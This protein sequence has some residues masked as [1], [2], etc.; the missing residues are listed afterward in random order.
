[1][2]PVPSVM[3]AD[4][5]CFAPSSNDPYVALA[6]R[7]VSQSSATQRGQPYAE[8]TERYALALEASRDAEITAS[9]RGATSA[10]VYRCLWAS[11]NKAFERGAGPHRTL[12]TRLFAMPLLIVTGGRDDVTVPGVV[13]DIAAR[14]VRDELKRTPH[15]G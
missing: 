4:P 2:L 14:V 10:G 13:P 5:R 15:E 3:L 6:E 11:L 9:L 12:V 8:L 1:M 7:W